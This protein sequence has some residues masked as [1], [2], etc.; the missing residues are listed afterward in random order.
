M[1]PTPTPT[2]APAAGISEIQLDAAWT[3]LQSGPITLQN[4]QQ[5][6]VQMFIDEIQPRLK[7]GQR[8][9]QYGMVVYL[10]GTP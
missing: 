6:Q 9:G 2:F 1:T 3:A 7:P 8:I 10:I 4:V 5:Y